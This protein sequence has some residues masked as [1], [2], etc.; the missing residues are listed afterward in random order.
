[1]VLR[2]RSRGRGED[3]EAGE[4]EILHGRAVA[5]FAVTEEVDGADVVSGQPGWGSFCRWPQCRGQESRNPR[6]GELFRRL[7]ARAFYLFFQ[8]IEQGSLVADPAGGFFA[9]AVE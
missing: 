6:E 7:F 5:G 1:M 8:L 9:F 2:K 3:T 4:V